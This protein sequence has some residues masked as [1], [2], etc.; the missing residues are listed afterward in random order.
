[1]RIAVG[2][3]VDTP[4][5][6]PHTCAHCRKEVDQFGRHGLNYLPAQSGRRSR[7]QT[8]NDIVLHSLVS[9]N[10]PSRLETFGLHL[11]DDKHPDGVSMVPWSAG[12]YL[13]WDATYVDTFWPYNL[14]QSKYVSGA[15]KAEGVKTSKYSHLD[16]VYSFQPIAFKTCGSTGPSSEVFLKDLG[17]RLRMATGEPK[18]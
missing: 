7:H 18:S 11:S 1:M 5:C 6:Q 16:R 13:A 12:K 14:Q 8:I 4:L 3:R 9:A 15:A 10:I 2:L 17:R